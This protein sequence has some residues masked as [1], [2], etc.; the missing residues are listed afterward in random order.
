MFG[1]TMMK[2]WITALLFLFASL[3]F[4][5][6][7]DTAQ[8]RS[9]KQARQ[10]VDAAVAA[11]GGADSLQKLENVVFSNTAETWGRLQ[12]PTWKGPFTPG[13][14]KESVLVD[15]K[16][17]RLMAETEGKGPAGFDFNNRVVVKS[18]EGQI[19]DLRA[20]T[21][22]PTQQG[23][24]PAQLF[25]QYQRRI[26]HTILRQAL[27]APLTLR[28]IGSDT[29]QGRK[30]EVV[31]LLMSDN[32]VIGMYFDAKT[33]LMSKYEL[34]FPDTLTGT[35]AS[36]I[37]YG[38]YVALGNTK[39]PTGMDLVQAGELVS[40]FKY[41]V[42]LNQQLDEAAF[43]TKTDGFVAVKAAPPG[44]PAEVEKLA[45]GVYL[46][47]NVAG[48]NQHMLAVEFKDHVLVV[49]APGSSQGTAA[50]WKKIKETIPNK[51]VKYL[52]VTHHHGDHTG[53]VRTFLD[54]GVT[55]V[56]GPGT[57]DYIQAEAKTNDDGSANTSRKPKIEVVRGKRV[58]E[59]ETQ[60]VEIID[61]GPN[62]HSREMLAAY[63]PKQKLLFQADLFFA[64]LNDAPLG[65]PQDTTV[66]FA[67]KLKTMGLSVE[68]LAGVHGKVANWQY[69]EQ[70]LAEK[71]NKTSGN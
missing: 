20:R 38:P 64:P 50:A 33:N 60:R 66:A 46:L 27:N 61:F 41:N 55:V 47:A 5:E 62:P 51:P 32:V 43:D 6:N 16:N 28:Y 71:P 23:N 54:E 8:K 49:E 65:P 56:A 45:D 68:R 21:A 3:G 12:M 15:L 42:K 9:Q 57:G 39:V 10:I 22:T 58:F 30:Q 11:L 34:L 52:V 2:T 25:I 7:I 13:T 44:G 48:P 40:R 4:A 18:G 26:P 53:G 36:Q 29:F 37:I 35:E 59:D 14:L 17:D 67:D 1:G 69:F 19:F 31:T 70:A 63:L 24:P